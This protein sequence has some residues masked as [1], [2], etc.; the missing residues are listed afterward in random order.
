MKVKLNGL[1]AKLIKGLDEFGEL[2]EKFLNRIFLLLWPPPH[3]PVLP[4][5]RPS[6]SALPHV[7]TPPRSSVLQVLRSFA[8]LSP[9]R[10]RSSAFLSPPRPRFF[11]F[12]SPTSPPVLRV[13]LRP[14]DI[15]LIF[16][17]ELDETHMQFHCRI[18][19]LL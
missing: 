11:T 7:R 19:H 3:S 10:P 15:K 13:P 5:H 16:D 4:V 14:L 8:F 6:T 2:L 18:F 9:P 17:N 12:L 1:M